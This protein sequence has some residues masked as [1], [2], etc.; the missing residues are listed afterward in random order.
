M[1]TKLKLLVMEKFITEGPPQE[2]PSQTL[3]LRLKSEEA[4]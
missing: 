3:G 4:K 1:E 2:R